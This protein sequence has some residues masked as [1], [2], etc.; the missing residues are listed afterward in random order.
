MCN[1][2]PTV[3]VDGLFKLDVLT[4]GFIAKAPPNCKDIQ[5]VQSTS[6][7]ADALYASLL[8]SILAAESLNYLHVL[9]VT[10]W[11]SIQPWTSLLLT[12]ETCA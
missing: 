8:G 12:A 3:L 5:T 7:P 11:H 6:L 10:V 4:T 2:Q 1:F 9:L